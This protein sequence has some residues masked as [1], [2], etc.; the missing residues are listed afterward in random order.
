MAKIYLVQHAES[1]ANTKG[2]YQGQ[3]YNTG[4][5]LLGKK[6]AKSLALKFAKIPIAKIITSPLL[7][8]RETALVVSKLNGAGIF[9]EEA[10]I[11]TNH[12]KWEGEKKAAI[13]RTWRKIYKNW[14]DNP[15]GV[16]FPGG[17]AF[18]YTQKRV[19]DWW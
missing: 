3:T 18:L 2:I 10:I 4:L 7:R 5:S 11:E 8:T 17:E 12:G 9:L 16:K 15:P 13:V 1:I 6:Q 19:L 14:L